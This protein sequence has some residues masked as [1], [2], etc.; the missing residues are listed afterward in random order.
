[1]IKIPP[2]LSLAIAFLTGIVLTLGYKD[3]Y[4]ELEQRFRRRRRRLQYSLDVIEDKGA[5]KHIQLEEALVSGSLPTESTV[6]FT[7]PPGEESLD[8]QEAKLERITSGV[9]IPDIKNGIEGTIGNTPLIR[10]KSLSDATG[11]DVLAKAEFLNGAGNSPKDR[12]ALS[13]IENVK[14]SANLPKDFTEL[15]FE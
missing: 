4:P 14:I 15:S 11:C 9:V 13:I 3:V 8:E 12:V 10:I 7:K 2:K 1:M 5:S 6:D